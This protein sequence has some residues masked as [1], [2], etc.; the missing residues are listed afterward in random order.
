MQSLEVSPAH[1]DPGGLGFGQAAVLTVTQAHQTL[2]TDSSGSDVEANAENSVELECI[3]NA[4]TTTPHKDD[5]ASEERGVGSK[6]GPALDDTISRIGFGRFQRIIFLICSFGWLSD[7][8]WLQCLYTMSARVQE[9]F[10]VP[11]ESIGLLNSAAFI[12]M[13]AGALIWGPVSDRWGRKPVF[14]LTM[15]ISG[16]FGVAAGFAQSFA[17]LCILIGFVG[18]GSGGNMPV[19]GA[20]LLEF[21]PHEKQ[22]LFGR[23]SILISVGVLLS[24]GLGWAILP[25]YSCPDPA[26]Q[27]EGAPPVECIPS[28]QNNGWRYLL[29]ILGGLS[30]VMSVLRFVLFR[31]IDTPKY[32]LAHGRQEDALEVLQT[33]ARVNRS[34]IRVTLKDLPIRYLPPDLEQLRTVESGDGKLDA[35][36][37]SLASIRASPLEKLR[38]LFSPEIM[39]GLFSH[40]MLRTTLLIW[41]IWLFSM[42]ASPIFY[43]F[44]PV[45]LELRNIGSNIV[46]YEDVH[47]EYFIYGAVAVF[48]GIVGSWLV[49]TRLGRRGGMVLTTLGTAVSMIAFVAVSSEAGS[50]ISGC[51]T[52]F[53]S[54]VMYLCM[55][56]YTPEVFHPR[57]RTTGFG[58]ALALGRLA[59]IVSPLLGGLMVERSV[60]LPLYICAGAY[61]IA[62][63]CMLLL[64]I[65]TRGKVV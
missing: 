62:T 39:R 16:I 19:D 9:H 20:V 14:R 5:I 8:M 3:S 35:Y 36:S 37:P 18:F 42:V 60:T 26:L 56:T 53:L 57:Y 61:I 59:G 32:L 34:D 52:T 43:V 64:P 30:I 45:F 2:S 6:D 10:S 55:C 51:F 23:L 12:G 25:H 7:E 44:L 48:G 21:L 29:F 17:A 38:R 4:T 24:S 49:G 11:I 27:P 65:E 54:T 40:T 46:T 50:M 47:R 33:I 15:L 1:S 22:Y 28:E 63:L 13:L 31:V 58:I 41:A